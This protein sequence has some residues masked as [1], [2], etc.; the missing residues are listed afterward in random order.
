MVAIFFSC[1]RSFSMK[2]TYLDDFLLLLPLLSSLLIWR[3]TAIIFCNIY[4][5]TSPYIYRNRNH[6]DDN[7]LYLHY[8]W[9]DEGQTGAKKDDWSVTLDAWL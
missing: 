1:S 5:V 9:V 3:S 4:T 2:F 7:E 6:D 8:V